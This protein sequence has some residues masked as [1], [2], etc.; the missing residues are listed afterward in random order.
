M[1]LIP[2]GVRVKV[3]RPLMDNL[4]LWSVFLFGLFLASMATCY[5]FFSLHDKGMTIFKKAFPLD[6]Y[7][8]YQKKMN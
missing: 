8:Q 7:I 6:M 1:T 4:H 2:Y 3:L 5:I